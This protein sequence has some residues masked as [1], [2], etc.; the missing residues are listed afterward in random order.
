MTGCK[1][2]RLLCLFFKILDSIERYSALYFGPIDGKQPTC[3]SK[4]RNDIIKRGL[5]SLILL[6]YRGVKVDKSKYGVH[7][8]LKR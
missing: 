7:F 8:Y 1:C 6:L 5:K 2:H 3:V 4:S